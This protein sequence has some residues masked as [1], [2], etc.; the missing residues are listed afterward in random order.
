MILAGC[1]D[2]G[3]TGIDHPAL[4]ALAATGGLVA[5]GIIMRAVL[6]SGGR[7][8]T[9]AAALLLLLGIGFVPAP[10]VPVATIECG[11]SVVSATVAQTSTLDGL[12]PG[13]AARRITGVITNTGNRALKIDSI[14]VSISRVAQAPGAAAGGCSAGDYLLTDNRM[15]VR[16][17][18][19]PGA[20]ANFGGARIGFAN[21]ARN[22]D[23]CKSATVYLRYDASVKRRP[24]SPISC[25]PDS[26]RDPNRWMRQQ[27]T[28]GSP[29]SP[30]CKIP[31]RVSTEA[32]K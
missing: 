20:S 12:A 15:R 24:V 11:K 23:A 27:A 32:K 4:A 18:L 2:L 10:G 13:V 25:A 9:T 26:P 6:R 28:P 30:P 5:L 7:V 19:A 16:A 29:G 22:Q 17:T 14:V 3:N 21:S 1:I 8:G 31:D